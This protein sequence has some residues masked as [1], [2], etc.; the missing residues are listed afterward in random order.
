MLGNVV[1]Q[2]D[3]KIQERLRIKII[4][5]VAYPDSVLGAPR[6]ECMNIKYRIFTLDISRALAE[7][8]VHAP[9]TAATLSKVWKVVMV[10][11][12]HTGSAA[13][14]SWLYWQL[15]KRRLPGALPP[16]RAGFQKASSF[17]LALWL[18]DEIL[19]ASGSRVRASGLRI[20][21]LGFLQFNRN[22]EQETSL[23]RLLITACAWLSSF[24]LLNILGT[25]LL[26]GKE[27]LCILDRKLFTKLHQV[28]LVP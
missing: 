16:W 5:Q 1:L 7:T 18:E 19:W 27:G 23:I 25:L 11:N 14:P 15:Q 22:A 3:C 17:W 20:E 26:S 24:R 4:E 12:R 28:D 6:D 9:T 8:C 10:T 13:S 21:G 2:H